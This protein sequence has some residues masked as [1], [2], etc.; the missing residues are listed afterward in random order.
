[1]S[2]NLQTNAKR[3]IALTKLKTREVKTVLKNANASFINAL[4]EIALNVREGTVKAS[5]KLK[6]TKL[7][8]ALSQK[9]TPLKI[10]Y[11][12]ICAAAA[13]IIVQ[14]LVSSV[15]AVLQVLRNG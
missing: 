3:L 10:K 7:V 2:Q 6:N 8:K 11:Q 4:S 1:M 14:A 12:L 13:P 5:N 15:L 9:T